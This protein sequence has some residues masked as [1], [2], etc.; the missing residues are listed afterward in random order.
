MCKHDPRRKISLAVC[1]KRTCA[2][3]LPIHYECRKTR[4]GFLLKILSRWACFS[5][6]HWDEL[7]LAYVQENGVKH[8][9]WGWPVRTKRRYLRDHVPTGVCVKASGEITSLN[10]AQALLFNAEMTS[11]AAAQPPKSRRRYLAKRQR[12]RIRGTADQ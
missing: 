11:S 8:A 4:S 10:Q 5:I 3:V 12:P 2:C 1:W 9:R 6:A 7:S